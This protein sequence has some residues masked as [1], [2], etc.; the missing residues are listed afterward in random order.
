MSEKEMKKVG[1]TGIM[2]AGKSSVIE[3][4]KAYGII[5][6]DCD[7]IN[8]D[9][10][11]KGNT[12]YRELLRVFDTSIL[13][14]HSEIDKRKMSDVVFGNDENRKKA[15]HI[16]HP[17]IQQEIMRELQNYKAQKLIVVEVPLLFEVK[18]ESFFD[19]VWVV[20]SDE[21][22]L[23]QRLLKYRGIDETEARRRLAHQMPQDVKIANADVVFYNNLDKE[24]LKRQIYDILKAN[25]VVR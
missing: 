21:K 14:E 17:L 10:L 23:L 8:A 4:L 19:E 25:E 11:K 15:E 20:A 22:L 7:K 12:G 2:G 18:W 16:L 9:L 13:D 24:N 1:L 5:V 3:L 6:L